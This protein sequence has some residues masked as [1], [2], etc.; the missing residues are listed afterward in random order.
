MGLENL[1]SLV[2]ELSEDASGAEVARRMDVHRATIS[3]FVRKERMDL[4]VSSL[5]SLIEGYP[6][7]APAILR[8]VGEPDPPDPKEQPE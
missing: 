1:R 6:D 5:V 7:K 3:R 2:R 8:A 4:R